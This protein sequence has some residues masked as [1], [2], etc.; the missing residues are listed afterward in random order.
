MFDFWI[1]S[2]SNG[3]KFHFQ[4]SEDSGATVVGMRAF[5]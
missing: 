3:L 4:E 5:S 1:V 2:N